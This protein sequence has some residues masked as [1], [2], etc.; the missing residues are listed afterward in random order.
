MKKI[1]TILLISLLLCGCGSVKRISETAQETTKTEIEQTTITTIQAVQIAQTTNTETDVEITTVVE[2]FDTDKPID[3]TTKAPPL[4]QRTTTSTQKQTK[5]NTQTEINI[6]TNIE[7][8]QNKQTHENSTEQTI[9]KTDK[10]VG[11]KLGLGLTFWLILI[12]IVFLIIFPFLKKK[13][14]S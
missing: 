6:Q 5:T 2:I 13:I 10:Q 12:S 14:H 9:T 8:N 4:K 11:G 7:T 1:F 3:P